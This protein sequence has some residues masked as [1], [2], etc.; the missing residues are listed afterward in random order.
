[1][2]LGGEN[3]SER[4]HQGTLYP[5]PPFSIGENEQKD[6]HSGNGKESQWGREQ[7]CQAVCGR[8]REEDYHK[9]EEESEHN[10]KHER[11]EQSHHFFHSS[12]LQQVFLQIK[13]IP[14]LYDEVVDSLYIL[15]VT[16]HG[17]M[18]IKEKGPECE[19]CVTL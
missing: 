3:V 4:P 11:G 8:E 19:A 7:Q 12:D 13:V 9:Q 14:H 15:V 10:R 16:Q 6:I 2:V 18:G 1:M 17:I 5:R